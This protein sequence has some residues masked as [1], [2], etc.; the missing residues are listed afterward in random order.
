MTDFKGLAG[1]DIEV[2]LSSAAGHR[3]CRFSR[4]DVAAVR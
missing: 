3:S 2:V 4:D 1:G